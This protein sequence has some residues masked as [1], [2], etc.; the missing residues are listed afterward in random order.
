MYEPME[1]TSDTLEVVQTALETEA[2]A[3]EAAESTDTPLPQ[4]IPEESTSDD[5][6][7]VFGDAQAVDPLLE[8]ARTDLGV[9][10][11][12]VRLLREEIGRSQERLARAAIEQAELCELFPDADITNLPDEVSAMAKDG[13]PIAAAYALFERK[14]LHLEKKAEMQNLENRLRSCGTLEKE[15]NNYFSPEEVR[16]MS[17]REVRLHYQAILTSMQKW[18]S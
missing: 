13:V 8:A 2:E 3:F 10:R 9:L 11:E 16:A 17:P 12:E 6:S 18:K 4:S 15:K 5:S 7:A 1:E 14:K